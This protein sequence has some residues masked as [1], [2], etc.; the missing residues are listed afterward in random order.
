MALSIGLWEGGRVILGLN[1][2]KGSCDQV[3]CF[4]LVVR[5][6]LRLRS[7]T[8][9][10]R[11]DRVSALDASVTLTSTS[12]T[13]LCC[14]TSAHP[15]QFCAQLRTNLKA[16]MP[17]IKSIKPFVSTFFSE[18]VVGDNA[19]PDGQ[20]MTPA[21]EKNPFTLGTSD[22][23][24]SSSSSSA[25]INEDDEKLVDVSSGPSK[26]GDEGKGNL[27]SGRQSSSSSTSPAGAQRRD[28]TGAKFTTRDGLES[29]YHGGLGLVFKYP[30][31]PRKLREKSK[32]KLWRDYF[33]QNGRNLTLVRYPSFNRL[34]QVGLPSRLR[35]EIWEMTSGSVFLRLQ[36]PGLYR[37]I[38]KDNKGKRSLA[39]DEIEKDLN[40]SL[41]EYPAYQDKEGIETLRRVLTAYAW[42][43]PVSSRGGRGICRFA[44][45]RTTNSTLVIIDRNSDTVRL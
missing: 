25:N 4:L 14:V 39:L 10:A 29:G 19:G 45:C 24:G 41:P 2:L 44:F 17:L 7:P 26:E 8:L 43:N 1:G 40:R 15:S 5:R 3:R 36:H 35:G 16:S 33:R 20:P 9:I 34:V 21:H 31:D 27:P 28:H 11:T 18:R 6:P 30:G 13:L 23:N 42:K 37:S 38:L 12:Q 22:G 32:M